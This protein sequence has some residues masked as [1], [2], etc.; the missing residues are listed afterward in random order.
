MAGLNISK[1]TITIAAGRNSSHSPFQTILGDRSC[2][3]GDN[4]KR[5]SML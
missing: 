3:L 5:L 4:I 2:S 1:N